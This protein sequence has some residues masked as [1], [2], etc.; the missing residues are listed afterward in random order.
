ME[1]GNSVFRSDYS[2]HNLNKEEA[3]H[4][5]KINELKRVAGWVNKKV[6]T[7]NLIP[8]PPKNQLVDMGYFVVKVENIVGML[9]RRSKP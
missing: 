4:Q 5:T 2:F 9:F 6:N 3:L 1:L 8:E 7:A